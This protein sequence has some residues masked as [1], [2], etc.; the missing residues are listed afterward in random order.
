MAHT[1]PE[2][3]A[4]AASRASF[5]PSPHPPAQLCLADS[6]AFDRLLQRCF[7]SLPD[8]FNLDKAGGDPMLRSFVTHALHFADS[9][10]EASMLAF[11]LD[12]LSAYAKPLQDL[13]RLGARLFKLCIKHWSS[14]SAAHA[15]SREAA[16]RCMRAYL[17]ALPT[18][19]FEGALKSS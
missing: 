13:P 14:N 7:S 12:G 8:A 9:L 3:P 17:N 6:D 18:A 10:S 11:V 19:R 2:D 1:R 4:A 5:A 15:S 16:Q